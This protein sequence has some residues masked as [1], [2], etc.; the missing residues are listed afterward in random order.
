MNNLN[1]FLEANAFAQ[2][3]RESDSDSQIVHLLTG[4][5]RQKEE[6]GPI[7]VE[8]IDLLHRLGVGGSTQTQP[9]QAKNW[10]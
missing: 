10:P 9:P 1:R 7:A 6:L 8:L 2:A 4:L 3:R 5:E